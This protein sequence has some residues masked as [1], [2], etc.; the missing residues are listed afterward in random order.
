MPDP[1]GEHMKDD[2]ITLEVV[3]ADGAIREAADDLGSDTRAAFFRKA[4]VGGGSLVAGGVLMGGLPTLA[5]AAKKSPRNDVKILNFALTLEYLESA[6]YDEAVAKGALSGD[7]L[8]AA[9]VVQKHEADHVKALKKV[10]GRAAVKKPKFD[11]KGTTADQ[12][13][14]LQTAMVLENTGV[15]AYS[16]QAGNI[17][18]LAV[19]KAA[20][21]ILTVEARHAS[22]FNSLNGLNFAPKSFDVAKSEKSILKA[23]NATGFITG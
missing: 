17:S 22:R 5:Q 23:V 13:K 10:L 19:L 1:E 2:L 16:G 9:Q 15:A 8:L 14:F 11:F 21:S 6:F 18:Q 3:D 12:T 4:A 7:A 20:V